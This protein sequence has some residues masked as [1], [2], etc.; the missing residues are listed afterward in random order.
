MK[1]GHTRRDKTFV[2]EGLGFPVVLRDVPMI[3]L[4]GAWT[5]NVDL[6]RLSQEVMKALAHK[7]ARLSG[8]EV[9]FIRLSWKM[10]LEAFAARFGVTHPAVLKWEHAG[11]SPTNMGWSTEKDIRLEVLRRGGVKAGQFLIAYGELTSLRPDD[12]TMS[13]IEVGAMLLST[14]SRSRAAGSHGKRP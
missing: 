14:G 5:P 3:C 12:K 2:Y 11:G 4:H 10:T 13:P 8:S 9:R 7:P 1:R 6:D